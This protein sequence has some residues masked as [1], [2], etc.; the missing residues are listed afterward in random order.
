MKSKYFPNNWDAVNEAPDE[1]FE[2]ITVEEFF[3][4]KLMGWIMPSSVACILR[5]QHKDTLKVHEHVYKSPSHADKRLLSYVEK[6][7]Y[8]I[9]VCMHDTILLVGSDHDPDSN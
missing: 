8:E 2:S 3:D 9:T 1:V 6:G 5:A 7:G 4:W